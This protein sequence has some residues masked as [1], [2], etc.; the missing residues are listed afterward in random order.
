[1][2][3]KKAFY[4]RPQDH[5]R[6]RTS[7]RRHLGVSCYLLVLMFANA[8]SVGVVH[9]QN[10]QF[11][12]PAVARRIE[13]LPRV[14]QAPEGGDTTSII[15]LESRPTSPVMVTPS[16]TGSADVAVSPAVLT[17]TAEDWDRAQAMT[18]YAAAEAEDDTATVEY[19]FVELSVSYLVS[20]RRA[21]WAPDYIVHV[22]IPRF[23]RMPAC[24]Q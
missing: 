7:S 1:M 19:V 3:N 13:G 12:E 17:F 5:Y 16:V 24:G 9:A 20:R 21:R 2:A 6:P 4:S 8:M 14:V 18:A 10:S 15:V 11:Y 22:G 23:Q